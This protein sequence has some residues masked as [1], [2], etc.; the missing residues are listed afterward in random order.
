MI[1]EP[2]HSKDGGSGFDKATEAVRMATKTVKATTRTVADA[3]EAGR[4]PGAPL[5]RLSGWT[6]DAPLQAIALAFL[7]GI[8]L[9]RR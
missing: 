2:L 1:D 5:D 7:L 4:Q 8:M 9:G 3:I 6:R